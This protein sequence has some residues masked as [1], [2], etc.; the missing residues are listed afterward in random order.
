MDFFS[1]QFYIFVALTCILYYTKILINHQVFILVLSS[2]LYYI[3]VEFDFTPILISLIFINWVILKKINNKLWFIG[4]IIL[5]IA[6]LAIFKYKFLF[7]TID[8]IRN[9]TEHWGIFGSLA[10][11]GLPVGIS[12]FIFHNISLL[13]DFSKSKDKYGD[14]NL[15]KIYLYI[16]FFPQLVC[17][18]ITKFAN[19]Y[20]QIVP[21][22][23]K[24]VD[25][26]AAIKLIIIGSFM[27]LFVANNLSQISIFMDAPHYQNFGS[28]DRAALIFTYSVQ[29]YADFSGYSSIAIG[30]A[31][32]F[33]YQL[34]I[35]FNL[36]Y[37]AS[38]FSNFWRRWHISLSQWL[39][40]YL[41]IPLGGNRGGLLRTNF[42]IMLVM[43]LGGLWHGA[44]MNYMFWGAFHGILLVLEHI[45][46]YLLG[47]KI[48]S[49]P[50][51]SSNTIKIIKIFLVFC[52]VSV[53]WV[54]FKIPTFFGALDF[55][56][57]ITRFEQAN[58]LSSRNYIFILIFTLP[59]IAQ[60]I[61]SGYKIFNNIYFIKYIN[62]IFYAILSFLAIFKAGPASPF[63]YFQF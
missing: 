38:S 52:A 63:I 30:L 62:P 36:P 47:K 49:N 46:S 22:Y 15:K 19:F 24:D 10:L 5:N 31:L 18:P 11:I 61:F 48:A 9:I 40:Q 51:Y 13:I 53:G 35:N 26:V 50:F 37:I 20:P 29:I 25:T 58:Q 23:W 28:I 43:C 14:I 45:T 7:L 41:Y 3:S 2:F 8:E 21:K 33:G 32:L 59:V 12:F 34:P 55:L 17:G 60:H 56:E 27:K 44:S 6:I 1:Y 54:L 57:G 42:N 16:I 4:G 39:Q